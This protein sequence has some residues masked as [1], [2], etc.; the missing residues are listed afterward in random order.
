MAN[1]SF[2][3]SV[4]S[5]GWSRRDPDLPVHTGSTSNTPFLS[6]LQSYNPFGDGGYVQLPTH[7]EAPGAP[8]PAPNRQAEEEG[9]FACKFRPLGLVTT[10]DLQIVPHTVLLDPGDGNAV[11]APGG[12]S[13]MLVYGVAS[14]QEE[15]ETKIK[16]TSLTHYV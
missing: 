15:M 3:D 7:N 1:N 6:R 5:L 11:P 14:R 8:L 13:I 12:F 16:A 2:R 10:S 4:N 9:F